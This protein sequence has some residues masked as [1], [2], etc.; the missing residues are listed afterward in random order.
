M[1][2]VLGLASDFRFHVFGKTRR[3]SGRCQERWVCLREHSNPTPTQRAWAGS[4]GSQYSPTHLDPSP[5]YGAAFFLHV[6]HEHKLRDWL[7][8]L[9]TPMAP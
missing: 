6:L 2:A 1:A 8:L 4:S 3:V 9:C 7:V 5:V